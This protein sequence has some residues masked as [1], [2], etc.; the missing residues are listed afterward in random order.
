M[1]K[2]YLIG[3]FKKNLGD[4][5][6]VKIVSERYSDAKITMM[7]MPKYAGIYRN[8]K[9]V[10]VIKFT[11]L[12]R[13][14]NKIRTFLGK[15]SYEI[16]LAKRS[17]LILEIG[18]S[19]FQQAIVNEVV[20]KRRQDYLKSGIP[21]FVVGSNFG[22]TI[23]EGYISAYNKYFSQIRGV[24]F[25]DS[26]SLELFDG[27]NNV[28]LAP[29]VVFLLNPQLSLTNNKQKKIAVISVISVADKIIHKDTKDIQ[30]KYVSK[31]V[32]IITMLTLKDYQVILF[33]FSTPENDIKEAERIF[34]KLPESIR[35]MVSVKAHDDINKSLNILKSADILISSR[36][37]SM[38]L[39]WVLGIPQYV[40]SYGA[41]TT[42]VIN[43]LF[44][45]QFSVSVEEFSNTDTKT[46][47]Q[48]FNTLPKDHLTLLT[49]QAD[50]QFA[51]VDNYYSE[52]M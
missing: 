49:D 21:T 35:Y 45:E 6:F 26:H 51:F 36:F 17:D 28:R 43:D 13:L 33:G 30:A 16:S 1:K 20:T 22:P 29:D 37:H 3:Y 25:R 2:I 39:G 27:L 24:V 7:V 15:D 19:I 5:L 46:I 48:R 42:D 52:L 31:M 10:K 8:L 23:D 47:L 50:K 40:I 9:N 41:K 38:I 12:R 34:K 11:F 14:I 18:G 4:D 44:P 32:N